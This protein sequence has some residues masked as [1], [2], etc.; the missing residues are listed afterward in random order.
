MINMWLSIHCEPFVDL[1]GCRMPHLRTLKEMFPGLHYHVLALLRSFPVGYTWSVCVCVWSPSYSTQHKGRTPV[2][3]THVHRS[4]QS[5]GCLLSSDTV[6]AQHTCIGLFS[7]KDHALGSVVFAYGDLYIGKV[8]AKKKIMWV[9]VALHYWST[10][11][12]QHFESLNVF[13]WLGFHSW[14]NSL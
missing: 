3:G 10:H 4:S 6:I 13:R 9:S 2:S 8:D 1:L 12:T 7:L 14:D 11:L 5:E